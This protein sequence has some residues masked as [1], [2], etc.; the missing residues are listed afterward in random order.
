MRV[1]SLVF[2]TVCVVTAG[3]A[4]QAGLP[5][6][7]IY[8]TAFEESKSASIAIIDM[9]A[10]AERKQW[11]DS[12]RGLHSKGY[13]D[14]FSPK[15]ASVYSKL[16]DPPLAD[17]YRRGIDVVAQYNK[18]M[19]VYATGQGFDTLQAELSSLGTESAAFLEA[20]KVGVD[21]AGK[22]TPYLGIAQEVASFA[23]TVRSRAVFHEEIVKSA[24]VIRALLVKM[25]DGTSLVFPRLTYTTTSELRRL[26]F[27]GTAK[28]AELLKKLE[29]MRVL[30]SD[31]V[32]LLNRDIDALDAVVLAAQHPSTAAVLTGTTETIIE[33]RNATTQ[34][35]AHIAE[36]SNS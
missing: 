4:L 27:G 8:N 23:L 21:V 22:V 17:V 5:E 13:D 10:V 25:R 32:I 28:R 15:Y 26:R 29:Q 2:V 18:V 16:A 6:F 30:L 24:P 31:W 7:K 35:R 14:K 19:L 36:I 33:L 20:A 12:L 1:R 9:L 34:I 3:C 11:Q